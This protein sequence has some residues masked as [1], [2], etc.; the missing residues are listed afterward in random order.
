[1]SLKKLS[2]GMI[3][4]LII[5]SAMACQKKEEP[6]WIEPSYQKDILRIEQFTSE[7]PENYEIIDLESK[8][9]LYDDIVF[10]FEASGSFLPLIW[11]DQTYDSYGISAYVGDHRQ[12]VNGT[13]EAVVSIAA[14]LSATLMGIDKS[15]QNGYNFVDGLNVYFSE[16]E[17]IILNNPTGNSRN[18][19]MW[20]LLYPA[21]LFTQVSIAYEDEVVLREHAL[22]AIDSWYEAYLVMH[23]EHNFD[24]TGFDFSTMKPYRNNIWK[25]PD[26]AVGISMLMYYGYKLTG[27]D[28]YKDA[29]IGS[30]DY[31]ENTY[32]G[33]P[34]YEILMYY[35]P[36]LASLYNQEFDT[37][38]DVNRMFNAIFNGNSLVRG[39]WGMLNDQYQ[40]YPVS[41]LMGSITDGGG[42]AFSMNTFSAAFIIGKTAKYDTRYASAIGKWLNH[43]I[44]NSR[45]YFSDYVNDDNESIY[46]GIYRD[47]AILFNQQTQSVFPYEGIRKA[48]NSK[49]PWFGG[50]PTVYG[51]ADTDL[52]IYSGASMGMLASMYETTEIEGILKINLNSGDY[53][54]D[55]YPTYLIY[56]PLETDQTIT[57]H[58]QSSG[59]DLYDSVSEKII[60]EHVI[61]TTDL[62]IPAQQAVVIVEI[63]N[64]ATIERVNQKSMIGSTIISQSHV[65]LNITNYKN[66]D[67]VPTSFT[68]NAQAL[69]SDLHDEVLRYEV[70]LDQTIYSFET[71]QLIL[72]ST[73]GSKT[74][75]ISVYTKEGLFDQISLRLQIISE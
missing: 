44:S 14:V 18:I 21:I 16:E 2:L 40:S 33:S 25:E 38:F 26:S 73:P 68:L 10:D 47:D 13:Q 5:V 1:M 39:G 12:G 61:T 9:L 54:H 20:Y 23:E 57:Y 19:S 50:D 4:A 37:A 74:L 35:A 72:S 58:V 32:Q 28:A 63:P 49:T 15:N 7:L 75:I 30:L 62:T 29:A 60:N 59:I 17:Q 45:Y 52:S 42:Y 71:D 41:G 64:D 31:I 53:Y 51:W 65:S 66:N 27:N 36:Y 46:T 3:M 56:N 24:Y 69:I 70:L 22:S 6:Q 34:M 8:A 11:N 67:L 55:A 43:L 48:G